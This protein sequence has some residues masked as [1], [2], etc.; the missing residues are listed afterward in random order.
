MRVVLCHHCWTWV[1]PNGPACPECRLAITL[2][3]PDP[4]AEALS[5]RLSGP[6][7]RLGEVGW[8]R[9][10]LPARGELWG[11]TAGLIYWPLLESLPNGSIVPFEH[12]T[13]RDH[14]WSIFSLWHR[15]EEP[16]PSVTADHPWTPFPTTPEMRGHR[17]LETPG[18]A[19][20]PRENLVK[21]QCH[22]KSWT[23]FRTLGRTVRMTAYSTATEWKPAW[24]TFLQQ[25]GWRHITGRI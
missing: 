13:A 2:D 7:E 24:Q 8:D 20:F 3:E 16:Q 15:P 11:T 19:F 4:S 23:L 10:R 21:I 17:F 9:P 14:A 12:V 6:A 25:D 5:A 18:A 22:R 1:F